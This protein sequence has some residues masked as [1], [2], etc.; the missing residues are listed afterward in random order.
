MFGNFRNYSCHFS[1]LQLNFYEKHF[2]LGPTTDEGIKKSY[3]FRPE[4][5]W[6][7]PERK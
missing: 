2:L 3:S 1:E 6:L 7:S 5:G 4:E